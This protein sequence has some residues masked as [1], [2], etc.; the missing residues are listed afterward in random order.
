MAPMNRRKA[1][2]EI[3]ALIGAGAARS[4]IASAALAN[5]SPGFRGDHS[6]PPGGLPQA[7]AAANAKILGGHGSA[8][9][10]ACLNEDGSRAAGGGEDGI[11]CVWDTADGRLLARIAPRLS[12][13]VS[14]AISP[15]G[16]M[17]AACFRADFSAVTGP[18]GSGDR[19]EGP[20]RVPPGVLRAPSPSRTLISRRGGVLKLFDVAGRAEVRSLEQGER[21]FRAVTFSSRGS[22]VAAIDDAGAL[23]AWS[24][25]SGKPMFG[26]AGRRSPAEGLVGRRSGYSFSRLAAR[27][28]AISGISE[29]VILG[30]AAPGG[31]AYQC[32]EEPVYCV[33]ISA[34]GMRFATAS[35]DHRLTIRS[36]DTGIATGLL[37]AESGAKAPHAPSTLVFSK[38]GKRLASGSEDG[39][40]RI[41][42]VDQERPICTCAGPAILPIRCL[43]FGPNCLRVVGGADREV[44]SGRRAIDRLWEWEVPFNE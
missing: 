14:L 34:N 25:I 24:V 35:R 41:W 23:N 31:R 36:S 30:D 20:A 29:V 40:V 33:A 26:V 3:G 43:D 12:S 42:N 32:G 15:D 2:A 13:I 18:E 44:R 1:L 38:D 7:L 4:P 9:A 10:A 19:V 28:A 27:A 22:M 17:V 11:I 39:V 37:Q 5:A 8:V 6:P 21:L 16:S